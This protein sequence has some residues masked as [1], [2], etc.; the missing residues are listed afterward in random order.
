MNFVV[1]KEY[2]VIASGKQV[3]KDD[4]SEKSLFKY[5]ITNGEKA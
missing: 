1:P 3:L 5:E 4:C 2:M